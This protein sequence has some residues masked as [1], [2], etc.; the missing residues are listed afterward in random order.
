MMRRSSLAVLSLAAKAALTLFGLLLVTF[1]IARVVPIDPVLAVVGDRASSETYARVRAEMGL[2][3][4]VAVPFIRY[5]GALAR[6]DLGQS[7]LTRQPVIEDIARFFPATFE[8]ATV[9]TLL[10]LVFG[11][12][13]GGW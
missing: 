8:L 6:G 13:V 7:A 11:L 3:R 4:P 12:P 2:D 9:A 5:V 1:L 10:G